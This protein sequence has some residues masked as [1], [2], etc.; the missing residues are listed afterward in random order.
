MADGI[1]NIECTVAVVTDEG[2]IVMSHFEIKIAYLAVMRSRFYAFTIYNLLVD[3]SPVIEGDSD[4][5]ELSKWTKLRP[6]QFIDEML[7][8]VAA[9]VEIGCLGVNGK[10]NLTHDSL[11][12]ANIDQDVICAFL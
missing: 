12:K 5:A 2:M 10:L 1:V 6:L 4:A 3:L 11:M 7:E 8:G 9:F